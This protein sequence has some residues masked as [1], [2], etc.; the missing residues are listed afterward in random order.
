MPQSCHGSPEQ[1]VR[2]ASVSYQDYERICFIQNL[3]VR[4]DDAVAD[5]ACSKHNVLKQQLRW[6]HAKVPSAITG[7]HTGVFLLIAKARNSVEMQAANL[8]LIVLGG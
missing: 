5:R 4:T 6:K 1:Q 8:L 2:C 7:W 3:V